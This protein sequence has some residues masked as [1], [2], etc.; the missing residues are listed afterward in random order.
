MS[1]FGW[2]KA[3]VNGDNIYR[4]YL[5]KLNEFLTWLLER[6]HNIRL[7]TGDASDWAAVEDLK[8]YRLSS[9]A[10]VP[11]EQNRIIA[12]RTF[13]LGGLME[14]INETGAVVVTRYHNLVG[15]LKLGRPAISLEYSS[16]NQALMTE[17]GLDEYCQHI[18]SFDVALLKRQFSRMFDKRSDVRRRILK[19]E[20][21]FRERLSA[22]EIVLAD[23]LCV[24]MAAQDPQILVKDPL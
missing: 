21:D 6:G 19:C 8:K 23:L 20:V 16:K 9:G 15:A 5:A 11:H 13:D 24:P 18:E 3:H 10:T 2:L 4:A 17:M 14:Q 1:Y 22:Q 7:L 12:V